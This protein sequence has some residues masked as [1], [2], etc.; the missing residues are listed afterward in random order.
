M[1]KTGKLILQQC[2][3]I[4]G[5]CVL[6]S[7]SKGAFCHH[8]SWCRWA[9]GYGR[10]QLDSH[11]DASN[12]TGDQTRLWTTVS[13]DIPC[14][15]EDPQDLPMHGSHYLLFASGPVRGG[16]ILYHNTSSRWSTSTP[17]TIHCQ[18]EFCVLR[19]MCWFELFFIMKFSSIKKSSNE[20]NKLVL[21]FKVIWCGLL[22]RFYNTFSSGPLYMCA[23]V[24]VLY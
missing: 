7:A 4:V 13:F 21:N 9:E 11:S 10:P 14:E 22:E 5:V 6:P 16:D 23:Q 17:V 3:N 18:R 20:G 12:V 19:V 8:F 1:S 2:K 24:E 15:S